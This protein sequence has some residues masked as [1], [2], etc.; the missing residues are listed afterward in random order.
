MKKTYAAALA[1]S[2]A[3]AGT[4]H[5]ASVALSL[6]I[7]ETGGSGPIF[8]NAGSANGI[9]WVNRDGQSLEL[10]GT[11]QQ[12]TFTP[13]TDTLLAFA[14]ATANSILDDDW[15]ALEHIR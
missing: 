6:G 11:W 13:A 2:L 7:R 4:V 10:D 8:S 9:E 15:A 14:G 3:A 12:F 5:A 1:L